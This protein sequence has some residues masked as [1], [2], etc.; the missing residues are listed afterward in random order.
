MKLNAYLSRSRHGIYYFRWP[1]PPR[2]DER[3][4]RATLRLSLR[5]RCPKSAGE[6]ARHLSSYGL[7]IARGAEAKDMRHEE[8][9]ERIK[10]YHQSLLDGQIAKARDVGPPSETVLERLKDGVSLTEEASED[11]WDLLDPL[12][13]GMDFLPEF[14]AKAGLPGQLIEQKA[15]LLLSEIKSAR[16][17]QLQ[18]YLDYLDTLERYDFSS[19][20]GPASRPST[21]EEASKA[22]GPLLS[23]AIEEYLEEN[24]LADSWALR[25]ADGK[26]SELALISEVLGKDVP[27]SCQS[28]S[29]MGQFPGA[30]IPV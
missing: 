27:I 6:M 18:A 10:A 19:G 28:R 1:L 4:R 22:R 15:P 8:I 11:Y 23:A 17:G 5:T 14:C 3:P 20:T 12:S 2:H 9:R 24:R 13:G 7:V 30:I 26:K 21:T 25:T 16:R 29:K